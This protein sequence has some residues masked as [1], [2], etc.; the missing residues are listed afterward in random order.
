MNGNAQHERRV[1]YNLDQRELREFSTCD[2]SKNFV[3]ALIWKE[4]LNSK[5]KLRPNLQHEMNK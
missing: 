4:S 2:C 3:S 1:N 5:V